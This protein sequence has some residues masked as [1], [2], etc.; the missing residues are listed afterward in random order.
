M[1][2]MMPCAPQQLHMVHTTSLQVVCGNCQWCA[3]RVA[4]L[5]QAACLQEGLLC[6][7]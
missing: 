7:V 3:T 1:F 2:I 6:A 4:C 5:R